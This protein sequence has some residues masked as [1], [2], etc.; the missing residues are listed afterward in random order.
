MYESA[1][2][3]PPASV[4]G[5]TQGGMT[6]LRVEHAHPTRAP[7]HGRAQAMETGSGNNLP[8]PLLQLWGWGRVEAL[9]A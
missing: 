5:S 6:L 3:E 8:S 1:P 2:K 4:L 9:S 7:G